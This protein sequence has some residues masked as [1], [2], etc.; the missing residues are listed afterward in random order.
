MARMIIFVLVL[1]SFSCAHYSARSIRHPSKS[2]ADGI[3]L[4]FFVGLAPDPRTGRIEVLTPVPI[5]TGSAP[6]RALVGQAG[7]RVGT[8]PNML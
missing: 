6:R 2:L 8:C 4:P 1:Q 7:M 5:G 3:F